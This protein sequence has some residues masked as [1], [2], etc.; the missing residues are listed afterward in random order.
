MDCVVQLSGQLF[1]NTQIPWRWAMNENPSSTT[2]DCLIGA[3][4]LEIGDG[5]RAKNEELGG[6]G[7]IFLRAGHVRD[8]HI[9]FEDAE[10]FHREREAAVMTKMCAPGDTIVTTKGNS[11]GRTSYADGDMPRFVYSPQ[12]C[13]WR[14]LRNEQLNPFVLNQWMNGEEFRDQVDAVKGQTDM[15]DY[16]SLRDQRRMTITSPF[17]AD[18]SAIGVYLESLAR[19]QD[20][21]MGES[22]TRAALRDTLLPQLLSGAIRLRR[23]E[24]LVGVAA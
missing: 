11:T 2:F 5:Y 13:F 22:R 9:D 17:T 15:A 3:E 12:L 1:A 19:R 20:A 10:R 8:T 6:D 21:N 16:V 23:A 18:Q 4:L 14:S 7:P 24:Q